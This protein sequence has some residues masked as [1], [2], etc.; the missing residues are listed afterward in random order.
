MGSVVVLADQFVLGS[1]RRAGRFARV[2]ATLD[3]DRRVEYD[4]FA[5]PLV[6]NASTDLLDRAAGV[7]AGHP[8]IRQVNAGNAHADPD[9]HVVERRGVSTD[10][11]APCGGLLQTTDTLVGI[12]Y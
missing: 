11:D 5:E 1:K 8:G 6:G 4:P 2:R 12:V 3:L 7:A 10:L 9:V